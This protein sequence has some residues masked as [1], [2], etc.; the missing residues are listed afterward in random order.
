MGVVVQEAIINKQCKYL[1]LSSNK[2]TSVGALILADALN[3]NKTLE[4]LVLDDNRVCDDGVY[5]LVKT[6]SIK[7]N[8]LKKLSLGNNGITNEGAK[9]LAQMIKTNKILTCL[10]LYQN[11]ITDGGI[12]IL[13]DAIEKHN[14]TIEVLDLFENKLLTDLSV[15]SLLQ[16]IE[17]TQSLKELDVS[18]VAA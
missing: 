1:H 4:E 8:I 3:D 6:L 16:M 13:A 10:K 18:R 5:S 11:E 17:H 7:N 2:I 12:Q 15:D 14:T 9:Q